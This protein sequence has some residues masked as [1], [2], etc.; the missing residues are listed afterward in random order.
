[1][2]ARSPLLRPVALL[3]LL[4]LAAAALLAGLDE[5]THE[6]IADERQA[7]ARG[8]VAAM[9]AEGSY[10]NDLLDDTTSL[11]IR[12]L[13]APA[14]V[15][16]ARADG[17]P[18]AA[19]LDLI[20]PSGYSGDIRLLVAIDTEAT[21]L[22]VRVLEHRETP[23]LGDKI[24]SSRSDWIEQFDGRSLGDP[25]AGDWSPDRRDGE[26]DTLTS[27]TITSAAVTDAVRHALE[28]FESQR[29]SIF[30]AERSQNRCNAK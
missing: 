19:V 22:G 10:D 8:A 28:A 25:P 30:G 7:H 9:L 17:K 5:L 2:T 13:E 27:A 24:E 29:A 14:T 16:R 21:V 15:Y 20:T 1:M 11:D 12:G 18:V 26:F 6:R 4:G 23:G 3:V